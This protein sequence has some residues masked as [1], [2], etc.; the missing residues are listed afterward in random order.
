VEERLAQLL[1]ANPEQERRRSQ[2]KKY[3]DTI[4]Q[5]QDRLDDLTG[6]E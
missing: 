3:L 2:L 4:T 6:D 5:A 1:A